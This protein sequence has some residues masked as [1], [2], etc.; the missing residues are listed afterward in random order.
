MKQERSALQSKLPYITDL[1][2]CKL[3]CLIVLEWMMMK[4]TRMPMGKDHGRS[5]AGHISWWESVID[6]PT[7]MDRV[8]MHSTSGW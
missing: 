6:Y 8:M 3:Q 5:S 2:Y 1:H 4:M 7:R